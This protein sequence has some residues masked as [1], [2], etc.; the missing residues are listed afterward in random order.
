[1]L[2]NVKELFDKILLG[3]DTFF[4][5]KEVRFAGKRMEAP[6][7]DTLANE[8]A[9]FS[10]SH[11][12]ICLLGVEDRSRAILGIPPDCLDI[13]E[14]VVREVCIDSVT[15]PLAP[16]IERLF[17][18]TP[19]GEKRAIIKIEI[20]RSLFVHKSPG[21]YLHRVGSSVR[22]MT[23]DF[24]ARLFQQRSQA[25][26]IRFDEQAVPNA[27]MEDIVPELWQRFATSRSR[28]TRDDLLVK[29]AIAARD[30]AG[31]LR[32]SVAGVLMASHDPRRWIPNAYIQAVAYS[33]DAVRPTGNEA[34]QFDAADISGPL[35]RQA[36][37]ACR[38]VKKNM[39]VAAIKTEGRRDI[40]QFDMTAVFEALVN[41]VA[42]RDYAIYGAKTRLR[43]F[44]D[45]LEIYSPGTLA[46][47]MTVE[48]LPY[49][50]AA[51]NEALTS[52]LAKCS[53]SELDADILTD[54][55]TLMDKRG[56]GVQ[57]I[58]DNSER[59]SGTRPEYRTIDDSEL[60]LIIHAA[61]VP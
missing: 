54:R 23:P 2:D 32:P 39:R 22:E 13:V 44:S 17:L 26:L 19:T 46:N 52:L 11:G 27:S 6:R 33:G 10:N 48:S 36:V 40:P 1:M 7:R 24:L 9:A 59:L 60:L 45:R 56:E 42:H 51:R 58:L 49:R 61:R 16:I 53:I 38:F 34:Y 50:Q 3:E 37:E 43:L 55:R 20:P 41:A 29:L 35:D 15:P 31:V 21:G 18:P 57:I 14:D 4:E 5:L 47:T 28:D 25:R 30:E 8:L 12:G